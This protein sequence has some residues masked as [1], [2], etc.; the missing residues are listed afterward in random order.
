MRDG[1]G[2]TDAYCVAK[3]GKKCVRTRTIV[4]THSPKLNEQYTW[5]VYG[6][7]S[8]ITLG[9]FDNC[10]LGGGEKATA[11]TAARDSRI[12]KFPPHMDTKLSWAE[13]VHPD[14]LD[15]EFDTFPTSTPQDV[16]RMRYDK[17]R[18]VAGRIQT[19]V[20][21]IP[22]QGERFH[23]LLSWRDTRATSLFV[24]FSLCS[25]V[26]LYAT[27]PKVVAMVTSVYYLRHP[28][29]RSKL[30]YVLINFFKKL[31]ARTDSM[32]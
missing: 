16:V 27:P 3:Y 32:L 21:D 2:S 23:S 14:E 4:D 18:S 19:V 28:K 15:E 25:A 17:L 26:V 9:V 20:A 11:S 8:V 12:G 31:P 13:A 24:V 10:H 29:F 7:C 30:P 22:T 1:H 5:E 6:P